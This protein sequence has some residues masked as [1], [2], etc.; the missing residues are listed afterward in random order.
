MW[1]AKIDQLAQRYACIRRARGDGNCFFRSFLY[2][3]MES[4]IMQN[5]IVE[6]DRWA[7]VITNG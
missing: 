7:D 3:Y 6:R 4:L 2:A 5:D 1:V